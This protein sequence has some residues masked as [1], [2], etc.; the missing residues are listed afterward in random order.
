MKILNVGIAKDWDIIHRNAHQKN[1][2]QKKNTNY[3]K[4]SEKK[5][6]K[7]GKKKKK[8]KNTTNKRIISDNVFSINYTQNNTKKY[9]D[10]QR[11][12]FLRQ[13]S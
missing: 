3:K 2:Y 11:R 4:E 10:K 9:I 12:I 1:L 7:E 5:R 13:L 6:K 8:K